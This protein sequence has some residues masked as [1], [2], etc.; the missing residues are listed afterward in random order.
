MVELKPELTGDTLLNAM[1]NTE[2]LV[3]RSTLVNANIID[4]SQNL[5][6]IVRAGAGTNTIDTEFA[7]KKSISVCNVPGKNAAAVAEL[8]IGLL[9]AIDRQI[10][11]NV[12]DLRSERWNK[13]RY[14]VARGLYQRTFGVIGLGAIG[15]A[16]LERAVGF[17]L[18]LHAVEN[19]DR[20][21]S[22]QS[23]L[24]DLNVEMM[25]HVDML[26]QR[27]DVISVHVPSN[28]NTQGM[29]DKQ[30]LQKLK[31]GAILINTS[32]G[33]IIDEHALIQALDKQ[34]LRVGLDV[35]CDEPAVAEGQFKS[36]LASHKCVYGTHHIGAST[37]QAQ[38][39]VAEGVLDV[40]EAFGR[41]VLHNC[42]N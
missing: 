26:I 34:D 3:V 37:L 24:R 20:S 39:A 23:R 13:K 32:R 7:R 11:D 9:I 16:V 38:N 36:A 5:K 33:D 31:P 30:F 17:G 4:S 12:F 21:A 15:L 19:P 8:V 35:Y 1:D 29:I 41:D 22:I 14:S 28:S 6:L 40:I 42:V 27:C 2:I 25:K 18:K 10:P